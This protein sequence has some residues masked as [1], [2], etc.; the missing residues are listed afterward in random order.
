MINL[1]KLSLA[2]TQT[3]ATNSHTI[4]R[5]AICQWCSLLTPLFARLALPVENCIQRTTKVMAWNYSWIKT[6]GISNGLEI[7]S[8]LTWETLKCKN[9]QSQILTQAAGPKK[10]KRKKN[11]ITLVNLITSHKLCSCSDLYFLDVWLPPDHVWLACRW[12][13]S[14]MMSL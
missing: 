5:M 3:M 2:H 13:T 11:I 8:G 7:A 6:D 10:R 14:L 1:K 4:H 9:S 12:S